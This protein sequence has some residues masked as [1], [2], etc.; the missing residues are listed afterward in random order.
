MATITSESQKVLYTPIRG[1]ETAATSAPSVGRPPVK[2]NQNHP[3]ADPLSS[4]RVT[5]WIQTRKPK[6]KSG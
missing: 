6:A 3:A 4:T 5:V 2:A 1:V